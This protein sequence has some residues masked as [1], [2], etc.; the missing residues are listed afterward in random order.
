MHCRCAVTVV[1][2]FEGVL[3]V[4]EPPVDRPVAQLVTE[5]LLHPQSTPAA[6]GTLLWHDAICNALAF[7]DG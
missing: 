1:E 7:L 6:R 2:P 3:I 5:L 4:A